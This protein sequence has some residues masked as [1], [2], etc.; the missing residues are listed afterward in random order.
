MASS[1]KQAMAAAGV[2]DAHA[3]LERIG[4]ASLEKTGGRNFEKAVS[5][6]LDEVC[7]V[8]ALA[9]HLLQGVGAAVAR[10]YLAHEPKKPPM[11]VVE[12]SAPPKTLSPKKALRRAVAAA[13][14]P[15]V[16][17]RVSKLDTFLVNNQPI[18]RVT[19][20]EARRWAAARTRD[21]RFVELL[22]ANMPPSAI[23]GDC[24]KP[25]EADHCYAVAL[26]EEAPFD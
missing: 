25:E 4:R 23:I 8:P 9:R 7:K 19:A 12:G 5:L 11:R 14:M 17:A 18:G 15:A 22:T 20:G 3:E 13:V 2:K 24:V 16:T 10:P 6:F 26:K 1:M 21:A